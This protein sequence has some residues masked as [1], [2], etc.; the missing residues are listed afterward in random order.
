MQ[1]T[2]AP[3]IRSHGKAPKGQGGWAFQATTSSTAFDAER[4]GD[5]RIYFGTLTEAKA[6]ARQAM[7]DKIVSVLG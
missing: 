4:Y 3:Y 2:Y 1:F 7:S 5:I 6:A